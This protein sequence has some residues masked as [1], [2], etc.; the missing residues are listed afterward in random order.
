MRQNL[1]TYKQNK[2]NIRKQKIKRQEEIKKIIIKGE[3][4]KENIE[5]RQK[6]NFDGLCQ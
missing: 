1:T 5:D 4:P 2:N 3:I 6:S